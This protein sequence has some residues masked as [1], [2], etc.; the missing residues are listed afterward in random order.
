MRLSAAA[1]GISKECDEVEEKLANGE[2]EIVFVE[3]RVNGLTR[4]LQFIT[5]VHLLLSIS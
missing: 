4:L 3:V 2:C 5:F 1:I